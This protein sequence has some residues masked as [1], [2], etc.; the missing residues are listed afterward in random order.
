[1]L[2]SEVIDLSKVVK[3]K[4]CLADKQ[5]E[6]QILP[7]MI[8]FLRIV[9]AKETLLEFGNVIIYTCKSSCW[10]NADKYVKETVI[11]QCEPN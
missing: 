2:I 3:C 8:R 1:M 9:G 11:V 7:T 6:M 5:F 4:K 10:G